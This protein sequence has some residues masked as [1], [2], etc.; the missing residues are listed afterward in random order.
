MSKDHDEI[1]IDH[2]VFGSRVERERSLVRFRWMYLEGRGCDAFLNIINCFLSMNL[3]K[4]IP[5]QPRD[6]M[7]LLLK[8]EAWE[9]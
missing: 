6:L 3:S 2:I 8:F 9:E 5:F 1:S 7:I 4:A